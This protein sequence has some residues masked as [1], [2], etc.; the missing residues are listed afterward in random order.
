MDWLERESKENAEGVNESQDGV[1]PAQGVVVFL[2]EAKCAYVLILM[3]VFWISESVPIAVTAL[4]P[5]FL[6]PMMGVMPAA[7]TAKSY[8]SVSTT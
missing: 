2:Q 1:S 4:L 5:L 8:M 3:A 6:F 7:T